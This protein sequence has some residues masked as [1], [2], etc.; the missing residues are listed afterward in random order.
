MIFVICLAISVV[1]TA[2]WIGCFYEMR[3]MKYEES[4]KDFKDWWDYLY[5]YGCVVVSVACAF[6]ISSIIGA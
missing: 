2:F 4:P 3:Q 1:L 6:G 5:A